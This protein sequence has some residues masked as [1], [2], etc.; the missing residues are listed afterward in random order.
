MAE[1]KIKKLPK[2][3]LEINVKISWKDIEGEYEKSFDALKNDLSVEGFRKGKAPKSIAEKHLLKDSVYQHLMRNLIPKVYEDVVKEENLKPIISPKIELIKAKENEDWEL[4]ITVAEKPK[5][6]LKNYKEAVKEAKAKEKKADIWVPGKDKEPKENKEENNQKILN[7]I[8][9]TLLAEASCEIPDIIIEEELNQRLA[10]LLDDIQKIGL[11]VDAYFKSK[12]TTMDEFKKKMAKEI[13]ET[14]K[15]EFILAEVA[16]KENITVEQN[17]L[18]ALFTNIKDE[19]EKKIAQQNA[20][21]YASILRK[22]KTLEFL[23]S[24]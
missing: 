12:G 20:Y 10:R 24:L 6:D 9:S 17:E 18:E 16:E 14:Y 21:F 15:L 19:K 11:T 1:H 7:A 22:Q 13:E 4:K 23:G 2:N 3:A 5:V 8:L